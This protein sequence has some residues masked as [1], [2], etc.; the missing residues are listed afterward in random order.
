MIIII[1]QYNDYF[2]DKCYACK[3]HTDI[4]KILNVK[5]QIQTDYFLTHF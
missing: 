5:I 1:T 2:L 3:T 4:E